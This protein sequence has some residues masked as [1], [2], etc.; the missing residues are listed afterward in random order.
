MPTS[1]TREFQA[2][3]LTYWG[4]SCFLIE[5]S[6]HRLVIDPFLTGNPKAAVREAD[7]QCDYIL[8]SHGHGDH[9]GDAVA[10]S[11][12]TGATVVSN[13]EIAMFLAKQGAKVHPMHIGGSHA[14]PFGRVKCTIAHHGSTYETE[15][16]LLALGNPMGFVIAADGKAVY[17]SGDTALFLDMQLIGK[18]NP[19][20]VALLPIGDNFTMGIEDA[21]M[22]VEFLKPK[23]AIP[24]HYKTFDIIDADPHEFAK[25][26][27]ALGTRVEVLDI[28]QSFVVP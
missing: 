22:A 15:T 21:T 11:K 16:G 4:H 3:K 1:K 13:Y 18:L 8:V 6:R 17:H 12:R 25:K 27:R 28:G 20:D 10:I 2:V 26:A 7:V 24:M 14:F 5:S 19:L 23:T 9:V